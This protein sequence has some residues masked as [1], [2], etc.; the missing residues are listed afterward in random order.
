MLDQMLCTFCD[1]ATG[2][3]WPLKWFHQFMS[4]S[5]FIRSLATYWPKLEMKNLSDFCPSLPFELHKGWTP[6]SHVYGYLSKDD[7]FILTV[8]YYIIYDVIY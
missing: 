5:T 4:P 8:I 6:F 3:H 7:S 1:C 2:L